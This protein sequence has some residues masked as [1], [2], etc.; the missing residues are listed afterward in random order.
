M[1]KDVPGAATAASIP[2]YDRVIASRPEVERKGAKIPYTSLS[3][4]MSSYLA[5]D[6][7]LVLRLSPA[8]REA[9]LA[10]YQSR[11]HEAYGTVQREYVDV[12][13]DLLEATDDLVPWFAAS[14][15]YVGGLRPKPTKRSRG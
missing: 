3:G 13:A 9:F 2:A 11:L 5:E 4:N 14:V 15:A 10:R 8:D 7:T 12:P 1:A 6:G